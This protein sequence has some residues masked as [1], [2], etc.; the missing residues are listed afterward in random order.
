[1]IASGAFSAHSEG[2]STSASALKP[3]V[4]ERVASLSKPAEEDQLAA[5]DKR[6]EPLLDCG[7]IRPVAVDRKSL[8]MRD[9]RSLR[10]LYELHSES[11][12]PR[13]APHECEIEDLADMFTLSGI[14]RQV[15]RRRIGRTSPC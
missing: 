7:A 12:P 3:A 10:E 14:A 2:G 4:G 6:C 13:D 9:L 8:D 1:M 11:F 15:H 5:C